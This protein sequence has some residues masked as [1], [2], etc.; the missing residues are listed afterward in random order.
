MY[1]YTQVPES[2]KSEKMVIELTVSLMIKPILDL[3]P[4]RTVLKVNVI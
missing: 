4:I 2:N 1:T 3:L